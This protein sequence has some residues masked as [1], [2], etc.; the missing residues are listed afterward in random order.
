MSI[1]WSQTYQIG[2]PEIDAAQKALFELANQIIDLDDWMALR[3]LIVALFKQMNGLFE[4]EEALMTRLA[5]PGAAA[6]AQDHQYLLARLRDR[7]MDVGK[8]LMNKKAIVSVVTDWAHRHVTVVD[9]QLA[10]Y[11]DTTA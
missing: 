4:L 11:I 8:G 6:H 10:Q 9:E 5:Y 7:S 2:N 3:P 1:E